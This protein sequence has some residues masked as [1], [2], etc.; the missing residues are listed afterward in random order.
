[1]PLREILE[2]IEAFD[3]RAVETSDALIGV[4]AG[5][6]MPL[7]GLFDR[8]IELSQVAL[9]SKSKLQM[10]KWAGHPRR[11]S[12]NL[13]KI[14]G[15]VDLTDLTRAHGLKFCDWLSVRVMAGELNAES[16]NRKMYTVGAMIKRATKMAT[17]DEIDVFG[18]L[19]F[20]KTKTKR[21]AGRVL[22][23]PN[24]ITDKF[25]GAD[26]FGRLNAHAVGIFQAM[27]NTGARP[28]ELVAIQ[29]EQIRLVA[30]IP[31]IFIAAVDRELKTVHSERA[32]PLV[33]VSLSAFARYSDGFK[34]YNNPDSYSAVM[35]K[36]LRVHDLLESPAHTIYSLR[37]GFRDRLRNVGCPDSIADV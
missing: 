29:P 4:S 17:G 19:L 1:M 23:S 24:W 9:K 32:I 36:N 28:S 22:F 6:A 14:I 5:F 7:S 21:R 37:H 33:G 34:R 35:M 27:I 2:R 8:H 18:G 26:N 15:D 12:D 10:K 16:A 13:L 11:C 20:P 25:V 30:D 3:P 31:H